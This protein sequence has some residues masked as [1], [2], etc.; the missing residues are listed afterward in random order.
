MINKAKAR[1]LRTATM[2]QPPPPPGPTPLGNPGQ[3]GDGGTQA[4]PQSASAPVPPPPTLPP[5]SASSASVGGSKR[6]RK[7]DDEGPAE[8]RRLRRSHEAC[9]RCRS[10]KIKCD[11][12]VPRCTACATAGTPCHQEDRQRQTLTPRGY[13]ERLERQ[14]AQMM[15]LLSRRIPNFDLNNLDNIAAAEGIVIPDHNGDPNQSPSQSQSQQHPPHPGYPPH[16]PPMPYPHYP[17]PPMP[18][19]PPPGF[20]TPLHPY[21]IPFPPQPPQQAQPQT[22]QTPQSASQQPQQPTKDSGPARIPGQDPDGNDMSHPIAIAT[23]FKVDPNI[24]A[25]GTNAKPPND[26]GFGHGAFLHT[27]AGFDPAAPPRDLSKWVAVSVP[28]EDD[29]PPGAQPKQLYLPADIRTVRHVMDVYFDRLNV[30]RPVFERAEFDDRVI[31]LYAGIEGA[32][33]LRAPRPATEEPDTRPGDPPQVEARTSQIDA[34]NDPGFISAFLYILALGTMSELNNKL[35]SGD[36]P[37]PV[38]PTWPQYDEFFLRAMATRPDWRMTLSS[39]Q[40]AVLL[41][42]YLYTDGQGSGL[43]RFVGSILRYAIELGLHHDPFSQRNPQTNKY[44]FTIAECRARVRLWGIVLI[45][46]R[47]T[48]VIFGRPLGIHPDETN[49]PMPVPYP[50]PA[51]EIASSHF[52]LSHAVADI[53]KEIILK[54]YAPKT[55]PRS[56]PELIG[57]AKAILDK[58]ETILPPSF[59][60]YMGGTENWPVERRRDL[61]KSISTDIGLTLL[62]WAIAKIFLLRALVASSTTGYKDKVRALQPAVVTAHNIIVVHHQLINQPDISFFTS[63]LP[64]Q[65]AA[66]VLLYGWMSRRVEAVT[67]EVALEDVTMALEGIPKFRWK[68]ERKDFPRPPPMM[69]TLAESVL[70]VKLED[71]PAPSAPGVLWQEQTYNENLVVNSPDAATSPHQQHAGPTHGAMHNPMAVDSPSIDGVMHQVQG[72]PVLQHPQSQ[73]WVRVK[74]EREFP[75]GL[76][77]PQFHVQAG[78]DQAPGNPPHQ[79]RS[80]GYVAEMPP[81]VHYGGA[82]EYH[83][84]GQGRYYDEERHLHYYPQMQ[85]R[86]AHQPPWNPIA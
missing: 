73:D 60:D 48:S 2:Q 63:P 10:K 50:D 62:K 74:L 75:A 53:Q 20:P 16:P 18:P 17:Y 65:T 86:G 26:I 40:A 72:S 8:P 21:Q 71:A 12:K 52:Y 11:S 85:Y 61:V 6:R 56:A 82:Y 70:Q 25:K 57:N 19:I 76:L 79:G 84:G 69:V 32:E 58:M 13:T 39:L 66:M 22:P 7:N 23:A 28:P 83:H 36:Q 29:A 35:T 44:T 49:T 77:F 3:P 43:W 14:V 4:G 51:R 54:L 81:D 38:P 9:A 45:H 42:W 34:R 55:P 80:G 67:R 31:Q 78:P 37:L 15:A 1:T 27:P 68:W 5:Q 41:H 59:R 64:L 24:Q 30:H 33:T 47:G 46:D